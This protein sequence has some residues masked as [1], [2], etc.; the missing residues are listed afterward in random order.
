MKILHKV[1][2]TFSVFILLFSCINW[3]FALDFEKW[4]SQSQSDLNLQTWENKVSGIKNDKI[5][6]LKDKSENDSIAVWEEWIKFFLLRIAKDLKNLFFALASIYLLILILKTF[7]TDKT[8]EASNNLKKGW[9]WVSLWLVVMQVSYPFIKVLFDKW[10]SEN[11][12]EEFAQTIFSPFISLLETAAGFFFIGIA[13]YSFYKLVTANWNEEA[14]KA[15]KMSIVY[16]IMWFIVIKLTKILVNAIYW[17]VNCSESS[18]TDII[19]GSNWK[20]QCLEPVQLEGFSKLIVDV[21]NWANGFIWIILVILVIY[22]WARV[23]LSTWN[24][25]TL[26]SSKSTFIYIAVWVWL[27]FTNYLI[28]TFF[29]L[30]ENPIG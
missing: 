27:L 17:K 23:L 8:E 13:I 16:A 12:A 15:W 6:A 10:V 22:T 4:Q 26:K 3:A 18:F 28:L 1:L 11:L 24:E 20:S 19:K 5:T 14:V 9:L 2:I 7:F 29:L 25:D 30:P 21:I